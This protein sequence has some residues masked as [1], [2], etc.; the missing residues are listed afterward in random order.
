MAELETELG[1]LCSTFTHI[2]RVEI[3]SSVLPALSIPSH[4]AAQPDPLPHPCSIHHIQEPCGGSQGHQHWPV[5]FTSTCAD[6]CPLSQLVCWF[7]SLLFDTASSLRSATTLKLFFLLSLIPSFSKFNSEQPA[8][9][10]L[11]GLLWLIICVRIN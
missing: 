4:R 6:S 5:P 2:K 7:Q 3:P 10:S 1:S 11:T 9:F 8:V